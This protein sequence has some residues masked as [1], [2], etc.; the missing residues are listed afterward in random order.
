MK[1]ENCAFC[2]FSAP[3]DFPYKTCHILYPLGPRCAHF[4]ENTRKSVKCLSKNIPKSYVYIRQVLGA[5]FYGKF[6][7]FCNIHEKVLT[8]A[9]K[10]S[11]Y[12]YHYNTFAQGAKTCEKVA[13]S[14][15]SK[16]FDHPSSGEAPN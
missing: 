7:I 4:R 3:C 6:S 8:G 2:E 14:E 12:H 15:K 1:T 13:K 5:H 16:F 10:Y 9:R 11:K